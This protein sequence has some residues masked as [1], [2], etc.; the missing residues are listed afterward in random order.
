MITDN[1]YL[2]DLNFLRHHHI[3]YHLFYNFFYLK[4][5]VISLNFI[6]DTIKQWAKLKIFL[7]IKMNR[8]NKHNKIKIKPNKDQ[9][10]DVHYIDNKIVPSMVQFHVTIP[11]RHAAHKQYPL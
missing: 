4:L 11:R 3:M 10:V 1:W 7:F 9:R 8:L 6:T 2:K 5:K